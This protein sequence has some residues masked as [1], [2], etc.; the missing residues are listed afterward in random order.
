[1]IF[2]DMD[3]PSRYEDFHG[4]LV[5]F[6]TAHF[7]HV[8]SGLQ[9]DSYCWVLDGGEKVSIDT[10]DAMK[11]QV[12]STRAGPHVQNVIS[13]LQ[14]RYKLKV[15]ENPELEAHEDDAAAT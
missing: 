4:E 7:T 2:A 6:L 14:Q 13:T 5:S 1:M 9:G 15:Y 12:K 11:H 8:E 10:F 3:Y